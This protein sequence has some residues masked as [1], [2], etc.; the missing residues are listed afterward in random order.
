[1]YITGI[2]LG[3]M[4]GN[5]VF[6]FGGQLVADKLENNHHIINWAIGAIFLI[7]AIIQVW[8]MMKKKDAVHQM[9]HPEEVT[10]GLEKK[11]E[12]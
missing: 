11:M 7:T 9:E 2:G 3:T 8:K 12:N 4:I 1:M 10:H 6:I 5:C